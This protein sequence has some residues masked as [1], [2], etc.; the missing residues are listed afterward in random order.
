M[1]VEGAGEP[2]EELIADAVSLL[3]PGIQE[4]VAGR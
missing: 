2:G 4:G 3:D 1:P